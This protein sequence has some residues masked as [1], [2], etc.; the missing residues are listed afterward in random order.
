MPKVRKNQLGLIVTDFLQTKGLLNEPYNELKRDQIKIATGSEHGIS[1]LSE[2]EVEHL[3]FFVEDHTKICVRYK[4]IV[5]LL[6]YTGVCFRISRNK[7]C[8][9]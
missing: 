7:T 4:L 2:K 8:G 5:Y 3:L 6:L 1:A 9:Y